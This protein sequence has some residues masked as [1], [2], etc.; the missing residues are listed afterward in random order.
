MFA[1]A[2]HSTVKV[3]H[4]TLEVKTSFGNSTPATGFSMR[5]STQKSE[6][7]TD[8]HQRLHRKREKRRNLNIKSYKANLE[9]LRSARLT[10]HDQAVTFLDMQR[11]QW[12]GYISLQQRTLITFKHVISLV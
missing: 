6:L 2:F 5:P 10:R 7:P 8:S 4:L 12:Y 11:L 1:E 9:R 3:I